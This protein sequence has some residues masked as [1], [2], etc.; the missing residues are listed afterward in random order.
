M[1]RWTENLTLPGHTE[2]LKSKGNNEQ[3]NDFVLMDCITSIK[4][5]GNG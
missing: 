5:K 4:K 1:E 3:L 2:Y